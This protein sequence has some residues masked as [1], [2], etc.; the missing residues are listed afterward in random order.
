M[1]AIVNIADNRTRMTLVGKL[2][3]EENDSFRKSLTQL[4]QAEPGNLVIDMAQL[5]F[6]DSAGLGM[7]LLMR[8][9]LPGNR[10]SLGVSSN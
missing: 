5:D 3:Y 1:T 7:L 6:I 8:D 4:Q 9:R 10:P 2:T